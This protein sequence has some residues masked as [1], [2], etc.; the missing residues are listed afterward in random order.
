MRIAICDDERFFREKLLSLLVKYQKE[1]QLTDIVCDQFS[2][3]EELIT[4]LE[5]AT[6]TF[7]YDI[8]FMDYE[9]TTSDGL[10]ICHK[11]RDTNKNITIIFITS[12][13]E[14]VLESFEVGTYRFFPKPLNEAGLFKALDTYRKEQPANKIQIRER[15]ITYYLNPWDIIYVESFRNSCNVVLSNRIYTCNTA[16]SA[17]IKL[18]PEDIFCRVHKSYIVNFSHILCKGKNTLTMSDHSKINIGRAYSDLFSNRHITYIK[19]Y[20]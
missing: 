10:T 13:P 11:I 12:Y 1:K 15:C 4:E 18:L 20:R 7:P 16:L 5:K 9:L 14:I 19:H 17:F 6:Y 2:S 8:V 3:G